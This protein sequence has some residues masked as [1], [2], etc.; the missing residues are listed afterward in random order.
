MSNAVLK[1][2]MDLVKVEL[3]SDNE[4]QS[5][6]SCTEAQQTDLKQEKLPAPFTFVAVREMVSSEE[7]IFNLRFCKQIICDFK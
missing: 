5:E 2:R 6:T 3:D 1:H 7:T 4:S